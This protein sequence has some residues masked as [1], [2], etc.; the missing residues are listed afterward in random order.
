MSIPPSTSPSTPSVQ[1]QNAGL[2]F[3]PCLMG[4]LG[5]TPAGKQGVSCTS[6]SRPNQTV[7]CFSIGRIARATTLKL[8]V[9]VSMSPLAGRVAS[10]A[11]C[12]PPPQL[13]ISQFPTIQ[14][15]PAPASGA[16]MVVLTRTASGQYRGPYTTSLGGP[17]H[18]PQN[19]PAAAT[20]AFFQLLSPASCKS[21][22][23]FREAQSQL[24]GR[25]YPQPPRSYYS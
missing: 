7:F 20:P 10:W 2:P 16:G 17:H 5:N 19:F 25:F 3:Y 11:A 21:F 4:P 13:P 22:S 24:P 9:H 1:L 14:T 6:T 18:Q 23:D 8:C 15:H 12:H